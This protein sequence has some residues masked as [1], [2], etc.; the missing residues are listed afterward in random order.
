VSV[1]L[2]VIRDPEFSDIELMAPDYD[3]RY[4]WIWDEGDGE[5]RIDLSRKQMREL[6]DVLTEILGRV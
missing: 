4:V 6:R 2:C 3:C 1:Q 5:N